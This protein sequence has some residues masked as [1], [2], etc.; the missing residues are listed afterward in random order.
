MVNPKTTNSRE[1]SWLHDVVAVI[2]LQ[3]ERSF[4]KCGQQVVVCSDGICRYRVELMRRWVEQTAPPMPANF[5]N[6]P[7]GDE[8]SP[9]LKAS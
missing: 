1:N 6:V 2:G 4:R 8:R 5:E 9:R 3:I 7:K